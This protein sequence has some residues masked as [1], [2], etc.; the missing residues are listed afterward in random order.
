MKGTQPT[1]CRAQRSV[2]SAQVYDTIEFNHVLSAN[3]VGLVIVGI[4]LSRTVIPDHLKHL[5]L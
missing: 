3:E 1:E 4:R 5:I 2:G